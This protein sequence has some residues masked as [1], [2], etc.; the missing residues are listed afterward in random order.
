M[1]PALTQGQLVGVSIACAVVVLAAGLTITLVLAKRNSPK[2]STTQPVAP[3]VNPDSNTV[4]PVQTKTCSPT[5]MSTSANFKPVTCNKTSDCTGC[6]EYTDIANAYTCVPVGGGNNMVN[7]S[8]QLVHPLVVN[9]TIPDSVP[10][11]TCSG[12]GTVNS[13]G[14]CKCDDGYTGD[15]CNVISY[16]IAKPGSY[17]LPAYAQSCAGPTTD[18]VL[19]NTAGGKGGQFACKCKPEYEALFTQTVE[20]GPCDQPL[21]CG[22]GAQQLNATMKAPQLFSVATGFDSNGNVK[23]DKQPVVAN[24]LTSA[25]A[26]DV[27]C[28]VPVSPP[29]AVALPGSVPYQEAHVV[30]ADADPRCNYQEASNYCESQID[31]SYKVVVRGSNKPG[32]PLRTR[33]YPFY[34][35]PV[36]PALQRC[37]DGYTG[38]NTTSN[39]CM[40][41]GKVLQIQP[42]LHPC[43]KDA[44]QADL[45]SPFCTSSKKDT[46]SDANY[47][48]DWYTSVFTDDGEWNGYFTC[49]ADLKYARVKVDGVVQPVTSPD[50]LKHP[51][52]KWKSVA[53]YAD[54]LQPTVQVNGVDDVNCLSATFASR[55]SLSNMPSNC[56]G[57]SKNKCDALAGTM[58]V[59]WDGNVDNALFNK[60]GQPW[61]MSDKTMPAP[62]QATFG[63]QCACD[64][65]TFGGGDRQVPQMPGYMSQNTGDSNWWQC[66]PDQCATPETP[67][68]HL[69][70]GVGA[71]FSRPRCVCDS[72]QTAASGVGPTDSHTTYISF[73][74]ENEFPTCVRDSCNPYGYHSSATVKCSVNDDCSGVCK[75]NKCYYKQVE[76]SRSCKYDSDCTVVNSQTPGVCDTASGKCVYQD[77]ER[78]ASYCKTDD[79]C[80][81]GVCSNVQYVPE[82]QPDG[83]WKTSQSGTCSGGCVCNVDAV[84]QRD[85]GS[86]LGFTCKKRCDVYPCINGGKDCRIDPVS[87]EQSCTCR[88]CFYGE[89]CEKTMVASHRGEFCIPG[90]PAG[91][92]NSCCEGTCKQ[93]GTD[94][95]KCQ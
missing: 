55:N 42:P 91:Q 12:H 82:L 9:Y 41:D 89:M 8:G 64:G 4:K 73:R 49:M 67:Q 68:A 51:H 59:P 50:V 52:F 5:S 77:P 85:F 2:A 29:S 53:P 47:G 66:V 75:K 88:P 10:L 11:K 72:G 3:P 48:S 70:T 84:Q 35:P 95:Y 16:P 43:C 18:S 19:V 14:T 86:V 92:Y 54:P 38:N 17:C 57:S 27:T 63:G 78:S 69:Y 79:D 93:S 61:F 83:T 56:N 60:D 1:P 24:R 76:N 34:Y 36:P 22:G 28:Y 15:K 26:P 94:T 30:Y 31:A 90:T 13:D 6:V 40:K 21:V 44:P 71:D 65:H 20:G 81:N 39:P 25:T 58:Q 7:A 74:P 46:L 62:P 23:F 87:G 80:S 37:P 33:A 45:S 32:D